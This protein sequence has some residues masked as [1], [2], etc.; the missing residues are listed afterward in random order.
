ML[1]V[2]PSV[3]ISSV[4]IACDCVPFF[5]TCFLLSSSLMNRTSTPVAPSASPRAQHLVLSSICERVKILLAT[6]VLSTPGLCFQ[7]Q[8]KLADFGLARA[9]GHPL[10]PMTP[11]VVDHERDCDA[12]PRWTLQ[13]VA[14]MWHTDTIFHLRVTWYLPPRRYRS[15]RFVFVAM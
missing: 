13:T 15:K 4:M 1:L 5:P 8:L 9:Y 2:E 10:Q 12:F 11:K 6:T 14:Q 3:L 7:G